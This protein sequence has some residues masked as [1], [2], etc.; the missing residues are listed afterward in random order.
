MSVRKEKITPCS[1]PRISKKNRQ[2]KE[3]VQKGKKHIYVLGYRFCYFPRF[4]RILELFRRCGIVCFD[5]ISGWCDRCMVCSLGGSCCIYIICIHLRILMTNMTSI[6]HDVQIRKCSCHL[7]ETRRVL[8]GEQELARHM[9]GDSVGTLV[10]KA[11]KAHQYLRRANLIS[12]T[13]LH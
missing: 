3:K 9:R 1:L 12:N 6:S 10:R 7:T 4:F 11:K 8:L 5:F 13:W 2:H